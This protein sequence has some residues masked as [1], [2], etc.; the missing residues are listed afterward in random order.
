MRTAAFNRRAATVAEASSANRGLKPTATFI[1]SRRDEVISAAQ[2]H[3]DSP[4]VF[5]MH[6][7]HEA[8]WKMESAAGAAHSK[9]WRTFERPWPTR[10]RF[11]VRRE[12]KRHAAL[13][14]ADLARL[15]S[16]IPWPFGESPKRLAAA[17]CRC[18]TKPGGTS[19]GSWRGIGSRSSRSQFDCESRPD[20]G[21]SRVRR[22]RRGTTDW[23]HTF[24]N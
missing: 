3:G 6:W 2:V 7:D 18:A 17:L 12:A 5:C 16:A 15:N 19:G 4:F 22:G 23:V 14:S 10:Q 8:A 1:S 9:T 11:G 13:D 24:T 21:K 20:S